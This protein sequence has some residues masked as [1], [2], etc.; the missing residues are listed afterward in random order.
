MDSRGQT[1]VPT[2]SPV[3]T[4]TPVPTQPPA[5][6]AKEPKASAH[7]SRKKIDGIYGTWKILRM[8]GYGYIFGDVSMK[9]YVGG[10]VTIHENRIKTDLPLGSWRLE[11]PIY[12]LTKQTDEDFVLDLR[13]SIHNGFGFRGD[14]VQMVEV[15]DRNQDE[16]DEFGSLFWIRDENHLIFLGPVCF[17]AE[18]I[19]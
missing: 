16:W 9:D 10:T 15:F 3:P 6:F 19:E 4:K 8:V 12:K 7:P 2:Q 5:K 11:H 1:P 18:K 17:L 13:T 14:T